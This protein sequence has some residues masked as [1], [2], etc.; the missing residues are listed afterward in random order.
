[1]EEAERR[2]VA[3]FNP[4][5]A[6]LGGSGTAGWPLVELRSALGVAFAYLLVVAGGR[7]AMEGRA[8]LSLKRPMI[9][10]NAVQVGL[11]CYMAA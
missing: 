8:A 2:V 7:A 5:L 11:C 6:A 9:A 1:M 3:F 4:E 10:Y